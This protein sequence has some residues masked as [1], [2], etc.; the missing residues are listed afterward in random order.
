MCIASAYHS[1]WHIDSEFSVNWPPDHKGV[2][3]SESSPHICKALHLINA[4]EDVLHVT[5]S[6]RRERKQ[7]FSSVQSRKLC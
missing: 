2:L 4:V 3:E 6:P 7:D 1:P 5:Y